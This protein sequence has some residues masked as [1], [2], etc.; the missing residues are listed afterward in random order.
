MIEDLFSYS[1]TKRIPLVWFL[2]S[3]NQGTSGTHLEIPER[4]RSHPLKGDGV[5]GTKRRFNT[6]RLLTV[7]TDRL[8]KRKV[9]V[10]IEFR[11]RNE[12]WLDYELTNDFARLDNGL[13]L[14]YILLFRNNA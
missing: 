10:T 9:K 11:C 14:H 5:N 1:F 4:H 13:R 12:L 2:S 7:K 6:G 3:F 8:V